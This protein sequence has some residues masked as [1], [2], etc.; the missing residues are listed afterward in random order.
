MYA[1]GTMRLYRLIQQG[2]YSV[3][4]CSAAHIR[5]ILPF[6]SQYRISNSQ[7]SGWKRVVKI[8]ASRLP[9][10]HEMQRNVSEQMKLFETLIFITI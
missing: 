6:P 2:E 8:D 5:N 4:I 7:A 1:A 9:M 3:C 10:T